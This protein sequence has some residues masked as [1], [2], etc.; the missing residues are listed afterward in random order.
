MT[1]SL[2][3]IFKES[4][5]SV[6]DNPI[7]ILPAVISF[8]FVSVISKASIKL[9]ANISNNSILMFSWFIVFSVITL[10]GLSYLFSGLIHMCFV[11]IKTKVKTK[12]FFSGANKFWL[13]N[14]VIIFILTL[15]YAIV[16][17][18]SVYISF[19]IGSSL[20][21]SLSY[22]KFVFFVIYFGFLIGA[23][24]FL[25]F[26]SFSLIHD[27]KG[28]MKSLKSSIDF[29]GDNYIL[30]LGTGVIFYVV[31]EFISYLSRFSFG[32][33]ITLSEAASIFLI[34]PLLAAVLSR[35]YLYRE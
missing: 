33:V 25:S 23:M 11:S 15:L 5:K 22:A 3:Y 9:S 4:L 12:D 24:L 29:T 19:F 30:V 14:F 8:I 2:I 10:I 34:Y 28:I 35:L 1:K 7:M 16:N 32:D 26:A 18:A 13:K 20:S 27:K 31:F 21:L 6:G 17:L